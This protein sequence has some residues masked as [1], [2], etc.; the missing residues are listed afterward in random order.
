MGTLT[1]VFA[2]PSSIVDTSPGI[3][4]GIYVNRDYRKAGFLLWLVSELFVPG[5]S[6]IRMRPDLLYPKTKV[7]YIIAVGVVFRWVVESICW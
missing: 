1:V 5:G 3:P 4:S 2:G 7:I 6:G